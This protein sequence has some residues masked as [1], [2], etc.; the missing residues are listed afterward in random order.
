MTDS[1]V[2]HEPFSNALV[3]A[4]KRISDQLLLYVLA[5]AMIVAAAAVWGPGSLVVALVALLLAGLL[6]WVLLQ[7]YRVRAGKP[8]IGQEIKVRRRT[9]VDKGIKGGRVRGPQDARRIEQGIDVGAGS[10]IRG[11]ITGGE[12]DTRE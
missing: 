9:K 4:V 2:P 6:G 3:E 1:A 5:G 8:V 10:E 7:A 12:V 11:G